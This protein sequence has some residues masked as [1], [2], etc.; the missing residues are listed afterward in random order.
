[1]DDLLE[2]GRE[3]GLCFQLIDDV[4]D[5]TATRG[6]LGK[7]VMADLREGRV[8]LPMILL[9]PRLDANQKKGIEEVV[10]SGEFGRLSEREVLE[11]VRTSGVLDEVKQRAEAAAR[12]A[13]E[14]AGR[15][16]AGDER[17]ALVH[18]AELL[19][20]RRF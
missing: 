4:L 10:S 17:E 7:P 18:A 5:F 20:S 2:F 16:P 15:L 11:V 13:V 8:T 6:E 14:R 9:Y 1:M 19:V 3:L 12:R